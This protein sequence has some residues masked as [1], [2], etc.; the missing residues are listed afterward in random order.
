MLEY[1]LYL[2]LLKK[3]V[4]ILPVRTI[5]REVPSSGIPQRLHARHF[6]ETRLEKQ[7]FQTRQ[8]LKNED[9]VRTLWRH[10]E[11][12]RNDLSFQ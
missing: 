4:K 12:N 7:K 11:T 8:L 2:E 3:L 6:F 1:P 5:S 10:R 9:I